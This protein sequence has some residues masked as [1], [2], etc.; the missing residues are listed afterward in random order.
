MADWRII[1]PISNSEWEAYFQLRYEVLRKPWNEPLGS[2]KCIDDEVSLHGLIIDNFGNA[3]AVS[4]IHQ[5]NETQCQIRFMAVKPDFQK[6]G[7]GKIMLKFI[8]KIGLNKYSE[9]KEIILHAREQAIQFYKANGYFIESESY[10]LFGEIQHY[11]M[12]KNVS[13]C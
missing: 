1:Q 7:I 10:V 11:L 12:K 2:E 9:T 8:E 5:V 4:R 13:L 3:L 6:K